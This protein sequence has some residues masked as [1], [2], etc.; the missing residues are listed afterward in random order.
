MF[1]YDA[2]LKKYE[3][4]LNWNGALLYLEKM[5]S[6]Y[7]EGSM[8]NSLVGFPWLYAVEGATMSRSFEYSEQETYINI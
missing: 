1:Y 5:Y 8:L 4:M 3:K 7:K 6:R 2:Q